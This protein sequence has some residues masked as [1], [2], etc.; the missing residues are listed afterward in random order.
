MWQTN[1]KILLTVIGTLGVYTL[2]ANS[3]PQVASEV[4]AELSFGADVSPEEIVAA[5]EELYNGAGGCIACHGLGQRAPNL[6]TAD[7]EGGTIGQR[8]GAR[9][10]GQ[11]CKAYL[12]ES[13]VNPTAHLVAGFEPIMPDMSVALSDNQ[14]WAVVAFLQSQGGQVT[15]TGADLSAAGDAAATPAAA[16]GP[17][18]A[19]T[20]PLEIMRGNLC[21]SCHTVGEEGIALGPSFDDIGSRVDADY[22]RHSILDPNAEAA[23]GYEHLLGAM[24]ATFGQQLTAAQLEAL[25][26]FLAS[27]TGA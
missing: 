20:E 10:P 2:V 7:A 13:M 14:I 3:I 25:V 16:G 11:D 8:C 5:G 19:S 26:E 9:V 6:L 17:A 24:P 22:I 1:L 27:R 4:P 21:F 12:H 18:T 15:V 23:E